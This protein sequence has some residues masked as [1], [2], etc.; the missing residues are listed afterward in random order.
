M[1]L[2]YLILLILLMIGVFSFNNLI[3]KPYP[4]PYGC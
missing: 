2:S 3:Y 1:L 4:N